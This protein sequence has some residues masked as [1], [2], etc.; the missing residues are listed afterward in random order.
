MNKITALIIFVGMMLYSH[1]AIS[2][3]FSPLNTLSKL[4]QGDEIIELL[5]SKTIEAEDKRRKLAELITVKQAKT[6]PY[7]AFAYY[8]I[9]HD[10]ELSN[11]APKLAERA[12]ENLATVAKIHDQA[13]LIAEAKMWQATFAAKESRVE[14]GFT[15]IDDAIELSKEANFTHL[16]GRAYNVKAALF[17]FQ[18]QYYSA[19]EYYL[20]ALD[21]FILQREDPYVS[22]VLSNV[23]LIYLEIEEWDK[24]WQANMNALEHVDKYGGSYEQLSVFNNNSAFIL[25]RL[26]RVD[27]SEPYLIAAREN[28]ALSGNL[29]VQLNVQIAWINYYLA[30]EQYLFAGKISRQCVAN[31]SEYQYKVFEA[32]CSRMLAKSLVNQGKIAE[33]LSALDVSKSYYQEINNQSGLADM[34]N[35]YAL[36]YEALGDFE[37]ALAHQRRSNEESKSLLFDKRGKMLLN[38]TESY[39]EKYREQEVA[40][41]KAEND[42]HEARLAEQTIREK[43]LCFFIL[44]AVISISLLIKKRYWLENDNKNLQ[45]SNLELY[46]QS[47]VDALTGLYN[48]RYFLDFL[49][50]QQAA[51]VNTQMCL[52]IIDIDHFKAVNDTYGHDIGDEVLIKVGQIIQKNIR[53]QDLLVRWGGE[54]FVLSLS[55]SASS[56]V[57]TVIELQRRFERVRK[58]IANTPISAGKQVLNLT[59]SIG[60]GKRLNASLLKD[61]WQGVL[62]GADK[63][64]YRAK[65]QGRDKVVL[66]EQFK[67][68]DR[69][70]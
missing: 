41:L 67:N 19:L 36:A 24:A 56:C 47:N 25:E 69:K 64:L 28:A 3:E 2:V 20:S 65:A 42:A 13:W 43:F 15:L 37:T 60:V 9:L 33:G 14:D 49:A 23:S 8:R 31:A 45:T 35:T 59:V 7:Y 5:N 34:F 17:F 22:K 27:E 40:L 53:E 39:K 61:C 46:K 54:E 26:D 32:D 68:I 21:I 70:S 11:G 29:R 57:V 51:G 16:T 12:I 66:V 62:E 4:T 48:R 30:T 50:Q 58:A 6:S 18:S 52:A 10:I 44:V 63:A 1:A 55:W 38:L